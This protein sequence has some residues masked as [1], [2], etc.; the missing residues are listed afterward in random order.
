MK[1]QRLKLPGPWCLFSSWWELAFL[2]QKWFVEQKDTSGADLTV[3]IT[4]YQWKWGYDYVKGEGEGI[5]FLS[6][7]STPE[8]QI[9]RQGPQGFDLSDGG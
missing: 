9:H 1:A 3:K 6:T 5:G 2:Q 4:G 7:L 8:S